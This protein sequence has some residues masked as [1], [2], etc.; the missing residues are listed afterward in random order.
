MSNTPIPSSTHEEARP[1]A[2]IHIDVAVINVLLI[3][4]ARYFVILMDE[5][6]GYL[7]AFSQEVERRRS[8]TAKT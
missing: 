3:S 4:G 7:R 5:V 2:G 8:C 6:S 1:G